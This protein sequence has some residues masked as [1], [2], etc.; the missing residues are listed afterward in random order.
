[1]VTSL[2][3]RGARTNLSDDLSWA[4]PLAWASK[5]GNVVIERQLREAGATSNHQPKFV[6]ERYYCLEAG[7]NIA[8]CNA[9]KLAHRV[10]S[11][12]F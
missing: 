7:Y 8:P 2:L 10:I 11:R 3:K 9:R 5:K 1:M 12:L 6:S 4:K